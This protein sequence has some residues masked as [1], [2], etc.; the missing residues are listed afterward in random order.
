MPRNVGAAALGVL[1]VAVIVWGNLPDAPT[2]VVE[3]V[4]PS[5]SSAAPPVPA[6]PAA[7][8][9]AMQA[10]SPAAG[11]TDI[12]AGVRTAF[13]ASTD[14]RSFA[15]EMMQRPA[16]GGYFYARHA[17]VFC[18]AYGD[19]GTVRAGIRASVAARGTVSPG[20]LK[21]AD[22]I[23]RQ[24]AGFFPG[25]AARILRDIKA[26]AVTNTDP[27][28]RA[29]ESL[30]ASGAG[31]QP[32]EAALGGHATAGSR[33]SV[34][35]RQAGGLDRV[36]RSDA[37]ARAAEGL[38]LDG[39]LVRKDSGNDAALA[40][41]ALQLGACRE[42]EP[43]GIDVMVLDVCLRQGM[44]EPRLAQGAAAGDARRWRHRRRD[45]AH[46]GAGGPGATGRRR[47]G[48]RLL[49]PLNCARR[50][51]ASTAAIVER[52]ASPS[53]SPRTAAPLGPL[54]RSNRVAA[55]AMALMHSALGDVVSGACITCSSQ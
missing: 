18:A 24:C 30:G 10:D 43:C 19:E 32:R 15:L 22:T 7:P 14:Y 11:R 35:A 21:A 48:R 33:R 1:A 53:R 9:P 47:E 17:V 51:R 23:V 28:L 50:V 39:R 5:R 4:A 45:R 16:E 20:Q 34:A 27:L 41:L 44:C 25:E 36:A 40:T 38:W 12:A 3:Q 52:R 42:S 49:R 13:Q 26:L 29:T 31:G 46:V 2:P 54:R 6:V 8:A 37:Q 55:S